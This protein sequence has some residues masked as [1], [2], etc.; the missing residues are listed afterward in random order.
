MSSFTSIQVW[1]WLA[2]DVQKYSSLETS[3]PAPRCAVN[4]QKPA[5]HKGF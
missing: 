4:P 2:T 3:A 1:S 5:S